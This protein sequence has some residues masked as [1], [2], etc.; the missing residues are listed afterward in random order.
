MYCHNLY[1][2]GHI[3]RSTRIAKALIDSG[4]FLPVLLTGCRSLDTIEIPKGIVVEK[5]T[6]LSNDFF[7]LKRYEIQEE[8]IKHIQS[9][10]YK[11]KP[12]IVLV[13]TVPLGYR[14]ELRALLINSKTDLPN[15][16]FVLGLPYAPH[17][18]FDAFLINPEDKK[19]I[20]NYNYGIK[21]GDNNW[22]SELGILDI[23][24]KNVGEIAGDKPPN[25]IENST[26]I[27][28]TG[29]GGA[30]SASMLKPM[31]KATQMS[32]Q[33]GYQVKFVIGPLADFEE[34]NTLVQGV[35][36][37]EIIKNAPIEKALR[38]AKIVISRCG[39]N[40]AIALVRTKLPIIFFP[41]DGSASGVGEQFK[42][43]RKLQKLKNVQLVNPYES[44]AVSQLENAINVALH[45][46]EIERECPFSVNGAEETLQFLTTITKRVNEGNSY[47]GV[48]AERNTI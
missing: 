31:L 2:L 7:D 44:D 45:S 24:F 38:D 3:I 22:G 9:F 12:H 4:R 13:D 41:Y 20:H 32:R 23:P 46:Q 36:N 18:G 47:N 11:F 39:Y 42:R 43:A 37:F 33:S 1:G 28:I 10:I 19:A 8:R 48:I 17:D 40:S 35:S 15:T 6:P 26:T 16:N 34:M 14:K 27:L 25:S 29:G 21:Y 30:V 5:L